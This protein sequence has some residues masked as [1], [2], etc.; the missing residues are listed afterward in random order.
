MSE[1]GSTPAGIQ[2]LVFFDYSDIHAGRERTQLQSQQPGDRSKRINCKLDVISCLFQCI[3]GYSTSLC[4]MGINVPCVSACVHA[5]VSVCL[6]LV[7]DE[8]RRGRP[9]PLEL[10][11]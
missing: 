2:K 7:P 10:E 6:C 4:V 3:L 8:A 1:G 5:Y 11:L 9:D